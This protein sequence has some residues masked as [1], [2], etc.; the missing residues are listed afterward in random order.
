MAILEQALREPAKILREEADAGTAQALASWTSKV[1]FPI[2]DWGDADGTSEGLLPPLFT[3]SATTQKISDDLERAKRAACEYYRFISVLGMLV[4]ERLDVLTV[5][6][7][8][9]KDPAILLSLLSFTDSDDLWTCS[10]AKAL[11]LELLSRNDSQFRSQG[12]IK[13]YLLGDYLQPLFSKSKPNGITSNGRRSVNPNSRPAY[14]ASQFDPSSKPWKFQNLSAVTVFSWV[15]TNIE[16]SS[17]SPL[18]AY[19]GY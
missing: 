16:V 7:T 4:I 18:L 9:R 2:L 14:D 13:E 10:D 5:D 19:L 3:P 11:A 15:V 8:A 17:G 12:F 1:I 6:L